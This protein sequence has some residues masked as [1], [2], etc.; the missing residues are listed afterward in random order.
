MTRKRSAQK[1]HLRAERVQKAAARVQKAH[2]RAALCEDDSLLLSKTFAQVD[3]FIELSQQN[4]YISRV[5]LSPYEVHSGNYELWDKVGRGV[6][7]L[8]S[9]R[10]L[11]VSLD[12]TLGEPDWEILA[13]ILL[14][15]ENKIELRIYGGRHGR[16]HFVSDAPAFVRSTAE[17]RAFAKAIQEHPAITRFEN[18][19]GGFSFENTATLCFA[20]NT[21][22]RISNLL[23]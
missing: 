13:R 10:S 16:S 20:L 17:M 3:H 14:H 18:S 1:A 23:L 6:G 2:L 9:L 8:K 15:I 19:H 22:S 5:F 4:T 21:H 7:N 11:I 12:N